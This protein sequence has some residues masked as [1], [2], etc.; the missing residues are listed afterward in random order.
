M[1][2]V[3]PETLKHRLEPDF[4]EMLGLMNNFN[5]PFDKRIIRINT[6]MKLT[7]SPYLFLLLCFSMCYDRA[8]C[9]G[10]EP[11]GFARLFAEI[12]ADHVSEPTELVVERIQAIIGIPSFL[13][14]NF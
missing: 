9:I 2:F 5:L 3:L 7:F 13:F 14:L 10:D 6:T 8:L 12:G 4:L 11:E 1:K